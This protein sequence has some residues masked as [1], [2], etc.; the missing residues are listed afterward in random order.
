MNA[1]LRT[2]TQK[3]TI[4]RVA[5]FPEKREWEQEKVRYYVELPADAWD[6]GTLLQVIKNHQPLRPVSL[7]AK[8][9]NL[10]MD[11][12]VLMLLYTFLACQQQTRWHHQLLYAR[13]HRVRKTLQ[14]QKP[15][16]ILE[17]EGVVK[18]VPLQGPPHVECV[19]HLHTILTP[20]LCPS[21]WSS[22]QPTST[23]F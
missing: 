16:R 19:H 11:H 6:D 9:A 20:R 5:C 12:E 22:T 3:H 18:G 10:L 17:W 14:M 1:H 8:K 23:H 13:M 15:G 21:W 7:E 2:Y 4:H